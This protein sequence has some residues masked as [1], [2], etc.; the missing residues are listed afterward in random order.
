MF[1]FTKQVPLENNIYKTYRKL[2]IILYF[3]A[4]LSAVY[5]AYLVLFPSAYFFF[6]FSTPNSLKNTVISPRNSEGNNLEHGTLESKGKLVFDTA[7][8]GN[9]GQAQVEIAMDKQSESPE[10]LEIEAR[11]SFQAF[12]YPEGKPVETETAVIYKIN[13]DYYKLTD[14]KLQKFISPNAYL[15]RYDA[16]TASPADSKILSQYPLDENMIG[17]ADGTLISYGISAYIVSSGKILPINN[18]VTFSA[19]GYNWKD[20]KQASADEIS[21][22]EKDKLFTLSSAHPNGTIFTAS[23]AKKSFLI[24]NGTKR[25]ISDDAVLKSLGKNTPIPI[26]EKSL[27]TIEKCILKKEALSLRTYSCEIQLEKFGGLIG[28]DYEFQLDPN[29]DI[30][31][32]TINV[33]FKKQ[34]N[35]ANLK[36][37]IR[38]LINRIMANYG[39]GTTAQ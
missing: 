4:F 7:L 19:M 21:F 32:D 26:S 9:Y 10:N 38:D 37:T 24:E 8:V 30:K 31:I 27:S 15:S 23:D 20:V 34:A 18:T 16:N 1:D 5:I 35:W 2:Q 13:E 36:S 33:T 22:Y 6:D 3:L 39:I 28:K 25:F 11:K 14:G 29:K 17:Y 12:F